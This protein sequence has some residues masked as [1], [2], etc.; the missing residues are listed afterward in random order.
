VS[1]K[2]NKYYSVGHIL[3]LLNFRVLFKQ[4]LSFK[5]EFKEIDLSKDTN[6]WEKIA[7][8]KK[9]IFGIHKNSA[10]LG[11]R[12]DD[13]KIR[14]GTY[15]YVDGVRKEE[16]MPYEIIKGKEYIGKIY[17]YGDNYHFKIDDGNNVYGYIVERKFRKC[18]GIRFMSFP[19][20]EKIDIEIII[21]LTY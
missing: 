10:R 20:A 13:G 17:E 14:I 3:G 9:G 15:C 19:Y 1:I 8:F 2:K 11:F 6:G 18:K 21:D 4:S 7:G 12:V 5:F 16:Y